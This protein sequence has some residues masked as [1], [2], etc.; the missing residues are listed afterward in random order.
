M[1]GDELDGLWDV[2]F[3]HKLTDL[4]LENP[5]MTIEAAKGAPILRVWQNGNPICVMYWWELIDHG[6]VRVEA[7]HALRAY[8]E[9]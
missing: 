6:V 9:G 5:G 2:E 7:V 1:Q 3:A 8:L 4:R